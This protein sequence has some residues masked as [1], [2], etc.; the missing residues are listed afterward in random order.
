MCIGTYILWRITYTALVGALMHT[1]Q[2]DKSINMY[3]LCVCACVCV[4]VCVCPLVHDTGCMITSSIA[5]TVVL[6]IYILS[7]LTSPSTCMKWYN[8]ED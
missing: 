6:V 7:E 8:L 2:Q 1:S 3:G 4:C 5:V